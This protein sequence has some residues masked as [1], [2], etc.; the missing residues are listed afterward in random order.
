MYIQEAHLA[1]QDK[2]RLLKD[3]T[4]NE[5]EKRLQISCKSADE[6][7][8]AATKLANHWKE[9]AEHQAKLAQR[10]AA[11]DFHDEL[12]RLKVEKRVDTNTL[13]EQKKCTTRS[14]EKHNF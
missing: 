13:T 1:L 12:Q 10:V 8:V 11:K 3:G 7:L 14:K 4:L 5:L 2:Y 6:T 9:E